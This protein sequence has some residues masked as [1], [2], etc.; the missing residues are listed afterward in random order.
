M[1]GISQQQPGKIISQVAEVDLRLSR[2]C[3]VT[4]GT[5]AN[6]VKLC[7]TTDTPIGVLQ[8]EPNIGEAAQVCIDGT[9]LVRA[10]GAFSKGDKLASAASTGKVDTVSGTVNI[11]GVAMEAAGKADVFVE[12]LIR[13][14]DAIA[15]VAPAACESTVTE[16]VPFVFR[17]SGDIT[18]TIASF[19]VGVA[20]A[21]GVIDKSMFTLA[22]TGAD[23]T[24]ALS[25]QGD[26]LINGVTIFSTKPVIAKAAADGA[27]SDVA[28][29]GV[30]VGVIN[31]AANIVAAGDLITHVFTLT[32]TTPETEMS[33][34]FAQTTVKSKVGA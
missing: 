13:A 17:T 34:L 16:R 15:T 33:G 2:Y 19:I 9:S 29:T 10:N 25:M 20:P 11:I 22:E 23:G 8:N 5:A 27:R 7:G 1:S 30:T 21:A 4:Q 18:A 14:A 28:G 6:S 31:A 24:D 12:M 3:L 32:R 26:T